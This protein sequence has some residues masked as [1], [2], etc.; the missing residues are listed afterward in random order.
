MDMTAKEKSA[1]Q[2]TQSAIAYANAKYLNLGQQTRD[3]IEKLHN[4]NCILGHCLR[5]GETAIE[6]I[7]GGVW[8][9][10]W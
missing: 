5:W 3:R 6:E 10:G 8:L 4:E 2:E 9:F 1:L 7:R